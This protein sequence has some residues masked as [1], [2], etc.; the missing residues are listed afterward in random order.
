VNVSSGCAYHSWPKWG[1]YTAAKAGMVAFT[2][3]LHLEMAEWGGKATT[4]IPG[5]ART[6]FCE[7]A[8]VEASWLE[9]YPGA[10]DFARTLVHCIDV[11]DNT[12]IEEV[13]VWGT[14]QVKEMLVPF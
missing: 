4:F 1:V 5:A 9:G 6:N 13:N 11:P 12:V 14:K 8:N 3:C 10:E 7:A 2:R